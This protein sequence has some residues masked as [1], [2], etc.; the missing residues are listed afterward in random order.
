MIK[1]QA[2]TQPVVKKN[3]VHSG[4]CPDEVIFLHG[5][6]VRTSQRRVYEWGGTGELQSRSH[7]AELKIQISNITLDS[8]ARTEDLPW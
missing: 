8:R 6:K 2:D 4:V 1:L 5:N 7:Q 3:S